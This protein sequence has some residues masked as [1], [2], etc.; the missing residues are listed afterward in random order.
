MTDALALEPSTDQP[1]IETPSALEALARGEIDIQITTAKRFPRSVRQFRDD[2][3]SMATISEETAAACFY[4]LKRD[5]RTIE[6]PSVRLAEIVASAW[7]NM[8]VEGR[9]IDTDESFVTCK[10]TAWDLQR[11]VALSVEVKKRI[12]NRQGKRYGDDMIAVTSN[13]TT[14]IAIRNAIFRVIPAAYT[15]DLYRECRRVAVGD[16][17]TLAD[18]RDRALAHFGK[19]GIDAA[20][21]CAALEVRGEADITLEHLA[22]L[23]GWRTSLRDGE[24]ELDTIFPPAAIAQPRRKKAPPKPDA[25]PP[26]VDTETGEDTSDA[27]ADPLITEDQRKLLLALSIKVKRPLDGWL[28]EHS[29]R[30]AKD[31]PARLFASAQAYL[32]GQGA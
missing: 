25:A 20:R 24:A 27:D 23:Q 10:G 7:G 13:A 16:A 17:S 14:S 30:G 8:R 15:Q 31:I 21:V 3:L 29:L 28:A 2:A 4:A 9:V 5:G 19:L 11:N 26:G 12:T 1:L 22:T 6:G 32:T 18:R